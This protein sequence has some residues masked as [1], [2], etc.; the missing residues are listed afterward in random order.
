M[1]QADIIEVLEKNEK[2]MTRREIAEALGEDL[3][4]ASHSIARLIKS[5]DIKIIEI[6]R[7]QAM[8]LYKCKRRMRLYYV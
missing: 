7:E 8:K 6:D 4:H 5:K 3:V 2:A 1:G